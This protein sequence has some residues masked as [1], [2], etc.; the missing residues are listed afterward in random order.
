M[1]KRRFGELSD[2]GVG[3]KRLGGLVESQM[4]VDA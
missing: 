2:V 3:P 1:G 4:T